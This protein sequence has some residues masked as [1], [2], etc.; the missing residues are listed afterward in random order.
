VLPGF[1]T[2]M[3]VGLVLAN[4]PEKI[5]VFKLRKNVI[6][7]IGGICLQLFLCMSLMT[8]NLLLLADSA[9]LLLIIGIVQ[10]AVLILFARS[11]VFRMMGQDYDAAV[12]VG[13]F[14]GMGLGA[15]P[16]A[17]ASMDAVATRHGP[18]LKALLIVPL[19][20]AFFIDI[21]NATTIAG[22]LKLPFM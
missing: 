13:G 15:T 3:L 12:M 8:M 22:F 17:I 16:V 19:V 11:L 7:I 1:L 4:A 20:G 2:A 10:V 21:I 18:S 5:Q 6:D 14:V 9:L